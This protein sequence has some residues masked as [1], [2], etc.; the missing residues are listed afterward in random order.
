MDTLVLAIAGTKI[1]VPADDD[2][3]ARFCA[4]AN[5]L[6]TLSNNFSIGKGLR[7]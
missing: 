3:M 6:S 1:A 7:R 2:S 5:N 4:Y